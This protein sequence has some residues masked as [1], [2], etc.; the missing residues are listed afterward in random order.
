MKNQTQQ[1]RMTIVGIDPVE[2]VILSAQ[3]YTQSDYWTV[4]LRKTTDKER[5]AMLLEI[6]EKEHPRGW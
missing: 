2:W 6:E 4:R 3:G 5:K 1:T